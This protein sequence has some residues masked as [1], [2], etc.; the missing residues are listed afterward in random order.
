MKP[1]IKKNNIITAVMYNY[2]FTLI[3]PQIGA[4]KK[5]KTNTLTFI[6]SIPQSKIFLKVT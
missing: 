6:A 1:Y 4:L 5:E 2:P 3:S